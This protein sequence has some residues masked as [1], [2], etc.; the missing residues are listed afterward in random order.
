MYI[1]L[2]GLD[3]RLDNVRSDVLQLKPFP[4]VEQAYAHVRK[5][6]IRQSVMASGAEAAASGAV[7]A[8]KGVKSAQSHTLVKS[9]SSSRSKGHS[10][11]S[12][13]THCGSA[14]HSRE[15]CFTNY[16]A[17]PTGGMNYKPERSEMLL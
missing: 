2:D 17:I 13:C 11:G 15:T 8:T 4:T 7:M 12:K 3:D 5:E 10:D 1:F 6:D 9:R 14:K 16:M